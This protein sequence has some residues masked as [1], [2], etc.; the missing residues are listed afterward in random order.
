VFYTDLRTNSTFALYNIKGLVFII[1]V[2]SVY[3][4]VRTDALYKAD[5][6]GRKSATKL[7][8]KENEFGFTTER[9]FWLFHTIFSE[10]V[11]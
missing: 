10:K 6:D 1:V 11:T 5:G 8:Q 3:S 4:A 2:E 7:L 9:S